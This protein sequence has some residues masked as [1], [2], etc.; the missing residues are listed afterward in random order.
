[1]VGLC[2]YVTAWFDNSVHFGDCFGV[3]SVTE[4]HSYQLSW[5]GY[6]H[7]RSC[8]VSFNGYDLDNS[9]DKYKVCVKAT[10]WTIEDSGVTLK[11]YSNKCATYLEKVCRMMIFAYIEQLTLYG[12]PTYKWCSDPDDIIAIELMT[13]SLSSYQ[14]QITLEVTSVKTYSY[15]N[16]GRTIGGAV[17][18]VIALVVVCLVIGIAFRHVRSRLYVRSTIYSSQTPASASST[19]SGSQ[20]MGGKSNPG[21]PSDQVASIVLESGE[22]SKKAIIIPYGPGNTTVSTITYYTPSNA[23]Y[24]APQQ[25]F[26]NTTTG[27]QPPPYLNS[28]QQPPPY[29]NSGQQPPPYPNSGQQP[30]P[31]PNSGQQ[32]PSYPNSGQQPPPYP[33][34]GQKP[35]PY[36]NSGQQLL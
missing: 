8:R 7:F 18:G 11:Y 33:N 9:M 14:G 13:S 2:E 23:G 1:M 15:H 3:H 16:Y 28:G 32:P 29:P 17:G 36:P 5:S 34:S 19:Q 21:Y 27:Q 6:D 25:G 20:K 4:D 22:N 26:K 24:N 31:Y 35:P 30:P 10:N 12:D